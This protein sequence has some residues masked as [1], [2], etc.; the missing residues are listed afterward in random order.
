[1]ISRLAGW[2]LTRIGFKG[3]ELLLVIS[4]FFIV[5]VGYYLTENYKETVKERVISD[6]ARI[7]AEQIASYR[8]QQRRIDLE[9][10]SRWVQERDRYKEQQ[11]QLIDTSYLE[12]YVQ[13]PIIEEEDVEKDIEPPPSPTNVVV[14]TPK[15]P[16]HAT[17]PPPLSDYKRAVLHRGLWDNYCLAVANDDPDC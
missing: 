8:E 10:V 3:P 6:E 15:D 9:V 17:T 13:Q 16:S 12:F 5:V 14:T 7:A 2:V 11:Q 4:L 1:M